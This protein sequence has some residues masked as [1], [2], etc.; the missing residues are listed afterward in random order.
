MGLAI[1]KKLNPDLVLLDI[2]MPGISGYDVCKALQQ[3]AATSKIP[4]VFLSALTQPQSKVSAL[5]AGGL[6]Y[7]TKPFTNETLLEMVRRYAVKKTAPGVCQAPQGAGILGAAVKGY[8]NFSDF[9]IKV[10]DS[11]KPDASG[12]KAVMAL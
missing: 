12:A 8:G 6:D 3:D 11:F 9:K 4:V 1:A 2:M 10:I 7:L 5:A